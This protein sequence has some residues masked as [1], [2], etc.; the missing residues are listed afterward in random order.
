MINNVKSKEQM[1][2]YQQ[3]ILLILLLA[4]V[5]P[6]AVYPVERS[7]EASRTVAVAMDV[8]DGSI[9]DAD[10]AGDGFRIKEI[11]IPESG[12]ASAYMQHSFIVDGSNAGDIRNGKWAFLLTSADGNEVTV[13]TA[14]GGVRFDVAPVSEPDGYRIED[15]GGLSGKIV[16]NGEIGGRSVDL[17]Y[18]VTLD[19]KPS[20]LD[21]SFEKQD[22][23]GFD[24][25]NVE[26]EV[27]YVGADYLYV[28]LEE[29]YG[30]TARSQFVREPYL[31]HFSC[32][33]ITSPYYAWIDIVAENKYGRD[34]YTIELPPY[35]Q[36]DIDNR[37]VRMEPDGSRE[38]RVFDIGGQYIGTMNALSD[39]RSLPGGLY[40]LRYC[41]GDEVVKTS[42]VLVR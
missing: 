32:K 27:R 2:K 33:H 13:E 40:I 28:T 25:Y 12:G 22:N 15:G 14:E 9:G 1:E 17:A 21:V 41:E 42:K 18:D 5:W 8:M 11:D 37:N 31:A 26:C 7:T 38:I 35:V 34:L 36:A 23:V 20:I 16:F 3:N 6:L 10:V 19:L 39:I 29:E 4:S 24:S 30:S